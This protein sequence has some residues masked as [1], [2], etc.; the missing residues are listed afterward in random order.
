M[1][2]NYIEGGNGMDS[3][4]EIYKKHAKTVYSFLLTKTGDMHLAEELTQETF[5]QAV[6]KLNEFQE[7][8]SV[9][10]WLCAIA[11]YQWYTYLRKRKVVEVPF[12]D[13][14]ELQTRTLEQN[15]FA[16]LS[17][18]EAV[19]ALYR[20][21]NPMKDV[22]YLRISGE[23]SFREIGQVFGK[24]EN[25]ARVTYYRAKE[26]LSKEVRSDE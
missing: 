26:K 23:L 14:E 6:R 2:T 15:V 18:L 22:V 11:K 19:E 24:S 25:W 3:M 5:Y 12:E 21:E 4:E 7:K 13:M 16:K 17:Q 20:L 8:S 9:V 1:D 10:T